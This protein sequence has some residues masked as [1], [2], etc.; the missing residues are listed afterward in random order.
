MVFLPPCQV[1]QVI[2][3]PP[4]SLAVIIDPL[5]LEPLGRELPDEEVSVVEVFVSGVFVVH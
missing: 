5:R 4:Q 3:D 2:M 1:V